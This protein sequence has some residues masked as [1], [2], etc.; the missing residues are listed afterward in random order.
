MKTLLLHALA[1]VVW[2]IHL[3]REFAAY[4][5]LRSLE[6]HLN[7]R[8]DIITSIVDPLERDSLN[9]SYKLTMRAAED[10][11][12]KYNALLPVGHRRILRVP[13]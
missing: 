13:A 10:A 3:A 11:A 4:F 1:A 9:A 5:T 8:R 7:D 6:I 12:I 2:L